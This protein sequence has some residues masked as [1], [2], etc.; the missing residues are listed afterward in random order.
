[1]L[2]ATMAD[3]QHAS[4]VLIVGTPRVTTWCSMQDP[5]CSRDLDRPEPPQLFSKIILSGHDDGI[6]EN[7]MPIKSSTADRRAITH[8]SSVSIFIL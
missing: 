6:Y 3:G 2:V 7:E 1:M 4:I 8:P 5:L